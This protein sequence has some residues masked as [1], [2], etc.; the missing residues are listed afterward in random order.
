MNIIITGAS[1]GVGYQ[2]ALEFCR[3]K[4][5]QVIAIS[6]NEFLLKQLQD[7]KEN[8]NLP[9]KLII[10]PY[11]LTSLAKNSEKLIQSISSE[12]NHIDILINNAGKLVNHPFAEFNANE[13][14]EVFKVNFFSPA[15]LIQLLLPWMG[16][17]Q[18]THIVNISSMGGF[19][20]SVKFPGLS[21][22]S[23]SKAA[24]ASLT[25]CL[26]EELKDTR[27]YLNCLALGAV[28]TEMLNEAFPG[29]KA[30]VDAIEMAQWIADF[31]E[32]GYKYFN[33]KILPVSVSTP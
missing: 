29:Y 33:G 14:Y 24:L 10:Q 9:G 17:K 25:E 32:N 28:Q 13:A 27:I 21:Y 5:N 7:E 11:D 8:N 22:Y 23:A 4:D 18:H 3:V 12:F 19:Q 2:L 20:G 16:K 26:A 6:R 30:P 31:S 1:K 15:L